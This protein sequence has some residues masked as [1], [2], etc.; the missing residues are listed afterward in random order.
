[1]HTPVEEVKKWAIVGDPTEVIRRIE[2]YNSAGASYHVFNF[3]TQ[4]H[5]EEGIEI[6]ARDVLPSFS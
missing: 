1:M 4:V 2:T 5:H 6:F 3:A